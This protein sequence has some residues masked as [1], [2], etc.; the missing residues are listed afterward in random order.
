MKNYINKTLPFFI[1]VFDGEIPEWIPNSL[2]FKLYVDE[3][4]SITRLVI[5]SKIESAIESVYKYGSMLSTPLG[6]SEISKK[7]MS[8]YLS[9]LKMNISSGLKDKNVVEIGCGEGGLLN[10][11]A[12]ENAIVIGFEPGPQSIVAREKYGLNVL[13][14][15]FSKTDLPNLADCIISSG[16]LEHITDPLGLIDEAHTAL[17]EGGIFFASVPN[18]MHQYAAGSIQELCHEHVSYFTPKNAVRLMK[19]RGF[20][21]C[22]AMLNSA[23]NEIFFWGYKSI[24]KKKYLPGNIMGNLFEHQLLRRYQKKLDNKLK[25]QIHNLFTINKKLKLKIGFYAGGFTLIELAGLSKSCRFFDGDEMK[26]NKKWLRGQQAIEPP[27]NL[28]KDPVDILVIYSEH[29]SDQIKKMLQEI[30]PID[31]SVRILKLS[32]ISSKR[33]K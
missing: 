17:S 18:S 9:A 5:D 32:E 16:C 27:K 29:Y 22:K 14:K 25:I 31:T 12:A 30:L 13:Q 3:K 15:K 2:P 26:W 4:L 20:E 33:W 23:G 10:A 7:R 11:I 24:N 28:I 1:G 21:R 6:T 19:S 8:E